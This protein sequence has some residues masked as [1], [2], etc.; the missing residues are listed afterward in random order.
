MHRVSSSASQKPFQTRLS[1]RT[2]VDTKSG[3]INRNTTSTNSLPDQNS[4]NSQGASRQTEKKSGEIGRRTGFKIRCHDELEPTLSQTSRQQDTKKREGGIRTHGSSIEEG[5]IGT[6]NNAA[7]TGI[8]KRSDLNKPQMAEL[9]DALVSGTSAA[10]KLPS[11]WP[12]E[13]MSLSLKV[14]VIE[15]ARQL[16]FP[17][18][19]AASYGSC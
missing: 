7:T 3:S 6:L 8:S 17:G 4:P 1:G 16:A 11:H 13:N 10:P 18:R 14:Q 2:E 12:A 5:G 15:A 9:V 19:R